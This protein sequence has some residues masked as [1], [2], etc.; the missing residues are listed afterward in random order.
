MDSP[1]GGGGDSSI[2]VT[3]MFFEKQ[4]Y[5]KLIF[6]LEEIPSLF[7]PYFLSAQSPERYS[8]HFRF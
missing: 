5:Q 7:L 1:W 4:K 6:Y 3:G 8:G 2:K